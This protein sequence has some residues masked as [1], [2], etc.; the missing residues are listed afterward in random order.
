[1]SL[2]VL[3]RWFIGKINDGLNINDETF[4]EES[5]KEET[6]LSVLNKFNENFQIIW[7][8]FQKTVDKKKL[9]SEVHLVY[10]V[11]ND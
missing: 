10:K 3:H 1:M 4:V 11:N 2:R 6:N 9:C 5:I 8:S 7:D